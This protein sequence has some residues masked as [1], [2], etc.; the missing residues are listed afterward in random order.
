M[1]GYKKTCGPL[2]I[3]GTAAIYMCGS[4]TESINV[5][6]DSSKSGLQ[7]KSF[8]ATCVDNV[9][10]YDSSS[11]EDGRLFSPLLVRVIVY[12]RK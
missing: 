10:Q 7:M 11:C 9:W 6:C 8:E 2:T 4:D 1:G 12:Q 5:I 3:P